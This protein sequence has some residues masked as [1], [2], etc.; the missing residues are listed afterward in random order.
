MDQSEDL[1]AAADFAVWLARLRAHAGDPSLAVLARLTGAVPRGR[2]VPKS[3][4][5][6]ALQ[7]ESLPSVDDAVSIAVACVLHEGGGRERAEAVRRECRERWVRAKSAEREATLTA[8]AAADGEPAPSAAAVRT[9]AEQAFLAKYHPCVET[10]L[11]TMELFGVTLRRSDFRYRMSTSY[12]SLTVQGEGSAQRVQEAIH[13]AKRVLIRGDAGSGKTT[14]LKWLAVGAIRGDLPEPM[15]RW[16]GATPFFLPLRHFAERPLPAPEDFLTYAARTL[17]DVAPDGFVRDALDSAHSLVLIDGVDEL[18]ASRRDEVRDWLRELTSGYPDCRYVVTSRQAAVTER[19]LAPMGFASFELAPMGPS[20]QNQF[21]EH[22]HT[23]MRSTAEDAEERARLTTYEHALVRSLSE[24]RELRRLGGNPLLCALLCALHWDRDMQ[25]PDDRV[26]VYDAALEMLLVRRDQQRNIAVEGPRLR[27]GVQEMLLRRLAYWMIRNDLTEISFAQLT[28]RV[29]A[30]LADS[31]QYPEESAAVARQL[32]ERSGLLRA[33]AH[34]SVDFVHR[35]FQEYLAADQL[36]ND[37]DLA[38]LIKH[39]HEDQWQDVVVMVSGRARDSERDHLIKSLLKRAR[40]DK[41]HRLRLTVLAVDCVGDGTA[42]DPRVVDE[43]RRRAAELIPPQNPAQAAA[44]ANL[45]EVV[46]DQMPGPRPE[47]AP[48]VVRAILETCRLVGGPSAMRLLARFAAVPDLET[49]RRLVGMWPDFDTAEF[50]HVVLSELSWLG[51]LTVGPH[52]LP[53][54][55]R[56]TGVTDLT[57]DGAADSYAV[58]RRLRNLRSLRLVDPEPGL[59]GL[60]LPPALLVL[61]LDGSVRHDRFPVPTAPGVQELWF[62]D[63]ACPDCGLSAW[64]MAGLWPAEARRAVW[65]LSVRAAPATL[66]PRLLAERFPGLSVLAVR[67]DMVFGVG[68]VADYLKRLRECFPALTEFRLY[69]HGDDGLD[70][71]LQEA[72]FLHWTHTMEAAPGT[73]TTHVFTRTGAG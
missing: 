16:N 6:R 48:G 50:A 55:H 1:S 32:L 68:E 3:T 38:L 70:Q 51:P 30:Y 67:S 62:D 31:A 71:Q 2:P 66:D 12:I 9:A 56:L 5:G 15:G 49:E 43:A 29:A 42:I 18:P 63:C 53:H 72:G 13:A 39:A 19:W 65:L 44:L 14:L 20:D 41:A 61:S 37:G 46:L 52:E 21:I 7:G 25:L 59:S 36:L 40:R 64:R 73:R 22:W 34:D 27:S 60:E 24:R 8:K 47:L 11:D 4:L 57:V 23:T 26:K 69:S 54:L 10:L 35:T 17:A 28:G 45:G 58:V 33:P